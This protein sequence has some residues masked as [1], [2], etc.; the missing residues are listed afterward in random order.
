MTAV[1]INMHGLKGKSFLFPVFCL[2]FF[3]PFFS[4]AQINVKK[5]Q[6]PAAAPQSS[7]K[8]D[9]KKIEILNAGVLRSAKDI[10]D[11]AKRLIGDV[12]FKHED[13]LMFCDSAYFYSNNSL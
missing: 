1:K 8:A 13:V 9:G 3:L 4:L 12:R 7:V 10:A 2:L 5:P 11:G 6:P